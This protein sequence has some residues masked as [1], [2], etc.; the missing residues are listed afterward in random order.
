M[1]SQTTFRYVAC[2]PEPAAALEPV[3]PQASTLINVQLPRA[4]PEMDE[5]VTLTAV[6]HA[7]AAVTEC[8]SNDPDVFEEAMR[9]QEVGVAT[10]QTTLARICADA[11]QQLDNLTAAHQLAQ[12]RAAAGSNCRAAVVLMAPRRAEDLTMRRDECTLS[13][14]I[15]QQQAAC[16]ALENDKDELLKQATARRAPHGSKRCLA[17]FRHHPH[18]FH[19]RCDSCQHAGEARRPVEDAG[20][21]RGT[22]S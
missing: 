22:A 19:L 16:S 20:G 2:A 9:S 13:S 14:A 5:S 15:E 12:A 21:Y 1:V 6:L 8:T 4:A 10:L 3:P 18:P 7:C 11:R 17:L